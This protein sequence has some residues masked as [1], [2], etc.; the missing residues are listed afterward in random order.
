MKKITLL[1]LAFTV[2][3]TMVAATPVQSLK[4]N[5]RHNDKATV[6]NKPVSMKQIGSEDA[7]VANVKFE[8]IKN[9][10]LIS[11]TQLSKD[12]KVNLFTGENGELRKVLVGNLV[13]KNNVNFGIKKSAK[14]IKTATP[15][16]FESFESWNGTDYDWIPAGWADVSKKGNV[17]PG[18]GA[19]SSNLTWA[20][21]EPFFFNAYDG[22]Y[23]AS[24]SCDLPELMGGTGKDQDE[25]LISP[26]MTP[27]ANEKLY[28]KLNY[29]PGW[30][31]LNWETFDFSG[32]NGN[33]E[34]LI[35][36]DGGNNWTK[37]WDAMADHIANMTEDELNTSLGTMGGSWYA[38]GVSVDKYVGKPIK[39]AFRYTSIGGKAEAA[40]IDAVK[41]AV[42]SPEAYYIRPEGSF[43]VGISADFY[44][45]NRSMILGPAY[46][47][48]KWRNWSNDEAETFEWTYES[49]V[50]EGSFLTT[51][52]LSLVTNYQ[53]N[54]YAMPTLKASAQGAVDSVYCFQKENEI[55]NYLQAGHYYSEKYQDGTVV[56]YLAG[57]YDINRSGKGGFTY[58]DLF[59]K[60]SDADWTSLFGLTGEDKVEVTSLANFFEKPEHPYALNGIYVPCYLVAEADAEVTLTLYKV[61][62][63]GIGDAIATS[64]AQTGVGSNENYTMI[65]FTFI[66]KDPVTGLE[67]DAVLTIDSAIYAELTGFENDKIKSFSPTWAKGYY[68]NDEVYSYI[69]FNLTK[70]GETTPKLYST[71][72]VKFNS[73]IYCT[74]FCFGLDLAYTWLE[75][76][77]TLFSVPN[78]G[79]SKDFV[80]D[81]YY[82][83]PG[84]TIEEENAGTLPEWLTYSTSEDE[85]TGLAT[86]K[87]TAEALPAGVDGRSTTFTIS[88]PGSVKQFN[89]TQ[90]TGG[91]GA[92][93]V[94][95]VKVSTISGD[96]NIT[97]PSS[98]KSVKIYNVAGQLVGATTLSESGHDTVSAQN[99]AKGLYILRFNDNTIV[100]AIK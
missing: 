92:I 51:N 1:S 22:K 68:D 35:S 37:A 49:P 75:A 16:Y 45:P 15:S 76:D 71:D 53:Y 94:S 90:G 21:D 29:A 38:F 55:G 9:S 14:D 77:D 66:E 63:N 3:G 85:T 57:T 28:F 70:D 31:K 65:H 17:A 47:D 86:L 27:Q 23:V 2:A 36:E 64:T 11:S 82:T 72:L 83:V 5:V 84:W 10:K 62:E 18:A 79:G 24:V 43:H 54:W 93:T 30:Y 33:V 32:N 13:E 58:S 61:D 39:V 52:E 7:K 6:Q 12:A 44:K 78:E 73:G 67:Q 95:P 19:E 20:A 25:W 69:K 59:G 87:L 60:G 50:T 26:E 74:S 98:I 88:V 34:V 8:N 80:I 4:S 42:P 46:T 100:K 48:S 40:A 99:L 97:Y 91:V 89:V 41:L 56:D 81:S 96:F